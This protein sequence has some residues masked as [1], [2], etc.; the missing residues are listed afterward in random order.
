[1]IHLPFPIS[2]DGFQVTDALFPFAETFI[3]DPTLE[4][5]PHDHPVSG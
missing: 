1:M 4:A 5:D 2:L 3:Y